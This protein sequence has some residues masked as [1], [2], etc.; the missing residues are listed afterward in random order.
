MPTETSRAKREEP[1]GV[2]LRL[3]RDVASRTG[4]GEDLE[5]G[6]Q[7]VIDPDRAVGARDLVAEIHASAKR[8]TDLKLADGARFEADQAHRIVVVG[9]S[10]ASRWVRQLARIELADL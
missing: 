2:R 8:P 7:G 4:A 3:L 6:P 1:A 10:R 5:A 9:D